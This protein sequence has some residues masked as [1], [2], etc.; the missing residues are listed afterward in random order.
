MQLNVET[1]S[2]QLQTTVDIKKYARPDRQVI[3]YVI[4]MHLLLP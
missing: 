4:S 3:Q 1:E 2:Q